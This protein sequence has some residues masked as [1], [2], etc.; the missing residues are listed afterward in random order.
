MSQDVER[1]EESMARANANY[2]RELWRDSQRSDGSG[3][4]EQRR[5]KHKKSLFDEV[6][7]RESELAEARRLRD[8]R[9]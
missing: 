6:R 3:A 5:E 2:E 1:A 8:S 9:P 4:Q 7:R